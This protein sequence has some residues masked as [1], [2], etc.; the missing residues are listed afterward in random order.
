MKSKVF[1]CTKSGASVEVKYGK[2]IAVVNFK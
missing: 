1:K 2:K